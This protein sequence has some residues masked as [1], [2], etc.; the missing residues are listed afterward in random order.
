MSISWDATAGGRGRGIG[1]RQLSHVRCVMGPG[2][3]AQSRSWRECGRTVTSSLAGQC[4]RLRLASSRVESRRADGQRAHDRP[5]VMAAARLQDPRGGR[6]APGSS[7]PTVRRQVARG[8]KRPSSFSSLAAPGRARCPPPTCPDRP[9]SSVDRGQ[10]I[11][12]WPRTGV[13]ARPLRCP[14]WLATRARAAAIPRSSAKESEVLA[15]WASI[16]N[17]TPAVVNLCRHPCDW[18]LTGHHTI[19]QFRG[20]CGWQRSGGAKPAG[21]AQ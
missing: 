3:A 12:I 14:A 6:K 18:T 13:P 7:M 2:P 20:A 4:V 11:E 15:W 9:T 21:F 17:A 5:D 19:S 8:R 1:P 16:V 10:P